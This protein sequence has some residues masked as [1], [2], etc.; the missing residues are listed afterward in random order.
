MNL[1]EKQL[2]IAD[3]VVDTI[4][5]VLPIL[6]VLERTPRLVLSDWSASNVADCKAMFER[7]LNVL[8]STLEVV[9]LDHSPSDITSFELS[10][11]NFIIRNLADFIISGDL[12]NVTAESLGD[13]WKSHFLSGL[14]RTQIQSR[15]GLNLNGYF[16]GDQT[17]EM[18]VIIPPCGMPKELYCNWIQSLS[19]HY[20]VVTWDARGLFRADECTTN[21][22]NSLDDQMNDLYLVINHF[23]ESR[24]VHLLGLCGGV[25]I[26]LKAASEDVQNRIASL[27]LWHGDLDFGASS[28]KTF[29]Q[30]NTYSLM[31]MGSGSISEAKM[32]YT[33]L[34]QKPSVLKSLPPSVA[35]LVIYPYATVDLFHNYCRLNKVLMETNSESFLSQISIPV[36][37]VSSAEDDTA[38][39]EG[40]RYLS[41]RLENVTFIEEPEGKHI[42]VFGAPEKLMTH[43]LAFLNKIVE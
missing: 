17:N 10:A 33:E 36:L 14:N 40:S 13:A 34:M 6:T 38:H 26:A 9:F 29:H 11:S 42:A 2:S 18:V 7:T 15:D 27:S 32:M 43:Q 25:V 24:K 8:D 20:F 5:S 21:F 41:E 39:P 4:S 16:A 1:V 30:K 19:V 28:M 23:G 3:K 37:V 35:H 12:K 31:K 22:G